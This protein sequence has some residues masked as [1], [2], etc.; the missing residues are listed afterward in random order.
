M[1]LSIGCNYGT[2]LTKYGQCIKSLKFCEKFPRQ[3]VFKVMLKKNDLRLL[4]HFQVYHFTFS[5]SLN[6][7]FYSNCIFL[8]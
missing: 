3:S 7:D 8:Q 5:E 2:I 1:P 6:A 4:S